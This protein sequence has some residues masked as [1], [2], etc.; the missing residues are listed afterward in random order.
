[1]GNL[2]H[3]ITRKWVAGILALVAIL[4]AGAI[5]GVVGQAEGPPTAVAVLP[6]GTDSKAAAELR[7]ELPEAEGSAAVV[8]YSSDA[9]LTPDQ[10]AVVQERART[11]PGAT[12]APPAVAEDGTA[13]TVFIPVNTSDAVETAEVVGDLREAAKAD[14]P[15]GLTAQVTGPAAIQA[16]L[17]AVFD[18]AN[19]RLLA[20]TASVV[21]LL[22]VI[23]YRSPVLW[24]VPLT[25]VGVADQL[26]AVAATHTL[27]AFDV[28]W[29]ESTIGILSVLVFGAG[30]DYALLLIS[31]YRDQLRVTEDRREAMAI[32]LRRTTEAIV[33]SSSTVVIGLLTLLLS[34]FPATRGL[35]LACAVGVVVAAFFVLVVLP[36]ALVVFGRWIFWPKV[37]KVGQA[38]LADANSLWRRIGDAVAKRPAG[39]VTVT[40]LAL[41]VMA[42]GITQI[43][44]GL[45]GPDQFL[46]KPEA[47]AAAER[48]G[49]SFPAGAA[50]PTIVVTRGDGEA[51]ATAVAAVDGIGDARVVA[52]GNGVSEIDAVIDAAPGSDEAE[53][54]VTALREALAG[55]ADTHVGGTEAEAMDASASAARDRLVIF[56]IILALVLVSLAALL[57]SVVA[58]IILVATVVATYMASLGLSWVLFTQVFGFERLDDGVPLLAFVFLVALG[59]DYNIFLIS[60]AAEEAK[61][62]GSRSGMLRA[63]AATGGVITSAGIL[64]AA[65]FAV[66]GVLPLVVLAQ[67]GVIIC[68]GVLLDTLVVRTVLVPAI[69]LILGDRFW[70]PRRVDTRPSVADAADS[71]DRA[72]GPV[73]VGG[74]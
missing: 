13:A 15:D 62:H 7:A 48:L 27:A 34:L 3:A 25:V 42:G 72:E 44:T 53:A 24:L 71:T 51:T 29:D 17:A 32:A 11:L 49:E 6:D 23:T 5:I 64:L 41:A 57:R 60:R 33:A 20:A 40:L 58:P 16:D 54:T 28:L 8:L 61:D 1:M 10:L 35:G 63:L 30:T 18:G 73:P 59:V 39:F 74:A 45:D 22:L 37:P 38:G 65:V 66:L 52:S 56:P 21:A 67:L 2:A 55:Q 4:G 19:F 46:Q 31:R 26:A 36:A 14:L 43:K 69:G 68:V 47:I 12:G 50:D 70:W 9:A